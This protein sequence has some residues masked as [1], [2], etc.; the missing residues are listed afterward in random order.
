MNGG[1]D[2]SGNG[3]VSAAPAGSTAVSGAIAP[4]TAPR[5]T[6]GN[7]NSALANTGAAHAGLANTGW[8]GTLVPLAL[9]LLAGGLLMLRKRKVS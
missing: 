4:V 2:T 7:G 3:S 1:T 6:A 5:S 9:L 8:D